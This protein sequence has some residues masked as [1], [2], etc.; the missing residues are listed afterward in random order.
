MSSKVHIIEVG[1][2]DGLQNESTLLATDVKLKFIEMLY[3]AGLTTIEV[4]SFVRPDR[5]PQMKDSKELYTQVSSRIGDKARLPCLVP[6]LKGLETAIACHV[7]EIALFTATSDE[8]NKKNINASVDESFVRLNEVA[9]KAKAQGIEMR[10]YLS[11]AFGCPYQGKVTIDSVVKN[12]QRLL[13]LG[14]KEVSIGDTIGVANPKLVTQ[15][16][17]ALADNFDLNQMAMHFHDTEGMALANILKSYEL[18]I[19]KFDSS[20]AGL[21]GCPY[22]RGATGNVATDDVV[23]MFEQMGV[24]TGVDEDKLYAASEYIGNALNRPSPSKYFNAKK[25]RKV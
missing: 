5:I 23:H 15:T 10:G 24:N 7:K 3:A 11:T 21:G 17:K 1:P 2:R 22:A 25:G 18:G 12:T 16:V 6:N 20:A 9:Q 4:T 13:D 8:F 14:A 19:T